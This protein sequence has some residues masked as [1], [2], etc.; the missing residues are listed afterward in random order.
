MIVKALVLL[1]FS[2]FG[3]VET[4]GVLLNGYANGVV[5]LATKNLHDQEI[6]LAQVQ[7]LYQN[8]QDI[9]IANFVAVFFGDVRP[10]VKVGVAFS[11]FNRE[12]WIGSLYFTGTM[13]GIR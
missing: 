9:S 10:A 7:L 5:S 8:A 6:Q 2:F 1:S 4:E 11:F 3:N 12:A 13:S